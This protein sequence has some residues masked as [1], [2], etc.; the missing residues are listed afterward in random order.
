MTEEEEAGRNVAAQEML[1]R[2][3]GVT[4]ANCRAIMSKVE[5]LSALSLMSVEELKPIMQSEAAAR[6]LHE[7]F[8]HDPRL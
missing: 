8:N 4:P 5:S 3:P 6:K 1:L 7:F 2:L